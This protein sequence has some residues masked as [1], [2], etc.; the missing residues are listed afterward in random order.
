M[1]GVCLHTAAKWHSGSSKA[2][3]SV[4][5]GRHVSSK[6]D[7]TTYQPL[8]L[9]KPSSRD[10][11]CFISTTSLSRFDPPSSLFTDELKLRPS[12]K[13][14]NHLDRYW[15]VDTTSTGG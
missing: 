14:F 6:P 1:A 10:L 11:Y 3:L 2:S 13:G 8:T 4:V 7:S 5:I 9:G 15:F 12:G